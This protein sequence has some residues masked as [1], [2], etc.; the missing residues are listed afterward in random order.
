MKHRIYVVALISLSAV[1]SSIPAS[2]QTRAAS[3]Q[4]HSVASSD[5]VKIVYDVRGHGDTALIFVHCGAC[6]R[7]FWRDQADAFSNNYRVVTLDLAGHGDSGKDRKQWTM[8]GLAADVRAVADD[9]HLQKMILIGHSL[10]GPVSLEAA[11]L[12][13]GRVKGVVLVDVI[14]DVDERES[15]ADTQAE[16]ERLRKDFPGYFADLSRAFSPTS[17]PSIRHWVEAQAKT[18]DPAATIALDLDSPNQDSKQLFANAKVPIR[19]INSGPPLSSAT[20]ITENRKYA[21][22][23]VIIIN[24]AGHFIPLERP[25]E[26]NQALTRWLDALTK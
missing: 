8:L 4:T 22:Y 19:A 13:P 6:N 1:A 17:D 7:H 2:A 21:D 20:N 10:G 5:G 26:F 9:L 18:A 15:V 23:D 11:R 16:V 3:V 24:D 14:H 12:M 25:Q